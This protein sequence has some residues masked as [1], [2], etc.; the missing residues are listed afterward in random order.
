MKAAA[1]PRE[2]VATPPE[3]RAP[4]VFC[5]IAAGRREATRVAEGE[6][7]LAI[8]DLHPVRPGHVLVIPRAHASILDHCPEAARDELWR[9]ARRVGAAQRAAGLSDSAT[10]LLL[11]GLASG[12]HFAHVHLHVI[13]RRRGDLPGVILRFVARMLMNA[14]GRPADRDRLESLAARIRSRLR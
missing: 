5:D 1:T 14:F 9:L 4:C 8:M 6:G 7:C 10:Y 3:P 13:P 11:D 12:Q 2:T